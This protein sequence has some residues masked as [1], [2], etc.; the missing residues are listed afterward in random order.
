MIF[1]D[2]YWKNRKNNTLEDALR[3]LTYYFGVD[4]VFCKHTV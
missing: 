3:I 2:I 1:D 4:I